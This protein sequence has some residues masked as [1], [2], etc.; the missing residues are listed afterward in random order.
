MRSRSSRALLAIFLLGPCEPLI[1]LLLY[2][3]VT[4][5]TGSFVIVFAVFAVL[6]LATMLTA[7]FVGTT[8]MDSLS[9]IH[10]RRYA[11]AMAGGT[12]LLCGLAIE[13]GGL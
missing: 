9:W 4:G 6:T 11:H 1:P 3:S 10:G 13:F 12:I 2:S 8:A 5:G 7:V